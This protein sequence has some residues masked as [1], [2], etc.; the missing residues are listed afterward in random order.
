LSHEGEEKD[1][2]VVVVVIVCGLRREKKRKCEG[3]LPTFL[4]SFA[5]V[6]IG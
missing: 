3:N 6:L 5:C 1:W 2:R 4:L